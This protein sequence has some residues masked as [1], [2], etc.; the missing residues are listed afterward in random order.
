MDLETVGFAQTLPRRIAASATRFES[1]EPCYLDGATLSSGVASSNTYELMDADGIVIGTDTWGGI[2]MKESRPVTTGTLV[3]Q[4]AMCACPI[5]NLG[6]IRGRAETVASV[7]TDAEI[8]LLIND[9]TLIDYN[10]TGGSDGGELYTIK[11]TASADTSAFTI[12]EGNPAKQT[13]D[14]VVDGR[15]YRIANDIT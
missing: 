6:R 4:T 1:G 11:E 10:S 5:P 12:V 7:D 8:L 9:V 14:V 3:A 13:L 2:F 15:A